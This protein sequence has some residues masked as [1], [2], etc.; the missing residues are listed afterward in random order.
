VT[1]DWTDPAFVEIARLVTKRTGLVFAPNRC[2]SLEQAVRHV[3][4]ERSLRDLAEFEH[5]LS[6]GT[7]PW[8]V[9]IPQITTGETYFFRDAQHFEFLTNEAL[10]RLLELRGVD[11]R[12]RV[13][14]AGCATGE[15]AYSLAMALAESGKLSGS[16]VLGTDLSRTAL[17]RARAAR[18]KKWSLRGLDPRL[19][20]KYF[21]W[22]AGEAVLAPEIGAQV[23]F[24]ELNLA[25]PGYPSPTTSTFSMDVILCR[26]VLI[27]LSA[28]TI[29]N[30]ARRFF[31]TLAPGGFLI[32]GPSD[33][34]LSDAGFEIESTPTGIVYR[35]PVSGFVPAPEPPRPA[36][37]AQRTRDAARS[38][39][40]R[41]TLHADE[42][43]ARA[44]RAFADGEHQTLVQLARAHPSEAWLAVLAVR[45]RTNAVPVRSA[46]T[47]CRAALLRH[48]L[49][50]ELHYLHALTL[51]EL[52]QRPSAAEA[53]RRAIYLDPGLAIAHF[54]LGAVLRSLEDMSGAERAYRNAAQRC[55]LRPE[56]EPV[57]CAR[58]ISAGGLALAA[59]RELQLLRARSNA[60]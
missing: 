34:L 53:L 4:R 24:Q 11:H 15:E 33:P 1:D 7:L 14:S 25:G 52:S 58:E 23:T 54:T 60:R 27:Y 55:Q 37:P 41:L 5:K 36:E 3:M 40:A 39:T 56:G 21:R 22:T 13:W 31:D 45:A 50:A 51:L 35:R 6:A 16:F 32:T 10:P 12:P 49:S 57:P 42:L 9:L 20:E 46:E 30:I 47:E 8:E 28:E 59:A 26:N 2:A 44:Q 17:V 18:Y 48:P 38:P 43:H 19:F 29:A